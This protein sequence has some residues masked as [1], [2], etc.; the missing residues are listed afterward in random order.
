MCSSDLFP[1]HDTEP[2]AKVNNDNPYRIVEIG[3]GLEE[4][5]GETGI[6][7]LIHHMTPENLDRDMVIRNSKG[8][9]WIPRLQE[10]R[11]DAASGE[12]PR[13]GASSR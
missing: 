11:K 8:I 7:H 9:R 10:A 13:G 6:L 12:T 4:T 3:K 5:I 1:S 2:I